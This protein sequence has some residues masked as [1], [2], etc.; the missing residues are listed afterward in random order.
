MADT[1][2]LQDQIQQLMKAIEGRLAESPPPFETN[3][4]KVARGNLQ[5][6]LNELPLNRVSAAAQDVA[7]AA[8]DLQQIVNSVP[9]QFFPGA[10]QSALEALGTLASSP[11]APTSPGIGLPHGPMPGTSSPGAAAPSAQ[12]PGT[13]S[14]GPPGAAQS[15]T[16]FA[17]NV[18][19][20]AIDQWT[21]F[22]QQEYGADGHVLH[23][24]H[25]EGED[26]WFKRVGQYWLEGTNT[27]GLD[28]QDHSAPW[29]AAFISWV[30]KKAGA[31]DRFRYSTQHSVYIA[32][33]IRDFSSKRDAAGFWG[34]RLN[35]YRPMVGDLVC[36][37]RQDG[38]DYDH[39]MGGDY[40]GHSD[41]VVAVEPGRIWIIG[42]NVG[43]SVT[44]R[45][46]LLDQR[47][48]LP[49]TTQGGETVFAIMQDRIS[50][51]QV[52]SLT[53]E[54]ARQERERRR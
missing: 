50:T 1:E 27:H 44:K 33:S 17:S 45:P 29:S 5:D 24:G 54:G 25:K 28:G 35:E 52:D 9:S 37:S 49:P 21:F 36:W 51:P 43:D 18:E 2:D 26:P 31:G 4:L 16:V 13:A 46:L 38:V 42:G 32:Q 20:I 34:Q 10:L 14:S 19:Q 41:I 11:G 8:N 6:A 47:G 15:P 53:E 12:A 30:M 22:G 48:F 7:N 23:V 3:T 40:K 39:Q